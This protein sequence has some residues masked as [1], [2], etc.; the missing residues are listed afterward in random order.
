MTFFGT[1]ATEASGHF[2]VLLSCPVPDL[3][4]QI[5]SSHLQ[6]PG[7]SSEYFNH[8][9]FS[10]HALCKQEP[11]DTEVYPSTAISQARTQLLTSPAPRQALSNLQQGHCKAGGTGAGSRN[12]V[13][14]AAM[15]CGLKVCICRSLHSGIPA[16]KVT[17]LE[18]A[19]LGN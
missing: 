17:I 15:C 7:L 14:A 13:L 12:T 1:K 19:A 16:S 5:L 11:V 4:S 3:W 10:L 6:L 9:W 2:G 18:D 8:L